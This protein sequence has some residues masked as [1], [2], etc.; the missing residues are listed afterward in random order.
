[1]LCHQIVNSLRAY[2]LPVLDEL[3]FV[4][5]DAI[6]AMISQRVWKD[7]QNGAEH[8]PHALMAQ[9][10]QL[11]SSLA[12]HTSPLLLQMPCRLLPGFLLLELRGQNAVGCEDYITLAKLG[13][14]CILAIAMVDV[15]LESK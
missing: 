1:V 12:S 14:V 10:S 9:Q 8:S 6:P 3:C 7:R 11:I 2:R 5:D 4:K 13:E 15:N